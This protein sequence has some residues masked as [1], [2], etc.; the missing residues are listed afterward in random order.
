MC[1]ICGIKNAYDGDPIHLFTE[2]EIDRIITSI[3]VGLITNR[4]LDLST[5]RKISGKLMGGVYDGYGKNFQEISFGSEDYVMLKELRDNVYHFSAA[6]TYQQ[7]REISA[8]LTNKE[9]VNPFTQFR[10]DAKKIFLEYN[11]NYLRAE[12]NSAISQ[13]NA[14]AQWQQIEAFKESAPMLTYHTV[15]DG[16]VRPTHEA[17][18]NISRP[19]DDKFWNT[20]Y[21]PNGWNCR[22]TVLQSEDATKTDLR[23]FKAPNDVPEIFRFN[24]GKEKIVFSPKHPYFNVA[25]KDKDFALNNFGL[26][27]P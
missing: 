7:T 15:G 20:Y 3:Y 27:M 5:Y 1:D 17:L 6:K 14:A 13:S 19:V 16:R 10:N 26:P 4:K 8:L 22:C 2:E 18:N 9:A 23:G 11:E 24:A 12:Y 21:P 25:K